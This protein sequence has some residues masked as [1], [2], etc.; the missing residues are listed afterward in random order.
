MIF[1][2]LFLSALLSAQVA[3]AGGIAIVD[4]NK[5]GSLVKEGVKIQTEL[6]ALQEHGI[7]DHEHAG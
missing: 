4:F 6:K 3:L 2:T 1:K 5:A 7:A